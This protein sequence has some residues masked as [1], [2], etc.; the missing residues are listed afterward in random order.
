M[1]DREDWL[2]AARQASDPCGCTVPATPLASSCGAEYR[3]CRPLDGPPKASAPSRYPSRSWEM[4]YPGYVESRSP[5]E[6]CIPTAPAWRQSGHV[7]G[8]GLPF[9]IA[10][11]DDKVKPFDAPQFAQALPQE[12][13]GT[14]S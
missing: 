8:A 11:L 12:F 6:R 3:A 13:R 14:D 7:H 4:L 2:R 5:A 1:L 9:C 10:R